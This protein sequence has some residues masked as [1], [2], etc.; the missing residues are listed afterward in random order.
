MGTE[1]IDL[2]WVSFAPHPEPTCELVAEPEDGPCTA[3]A[4]WRIIGDPCGHAKL[5][6]HPHRF[7]IE[8]FVAYAMAR[9]DEVG[10]TDGSPMFCGVCKAD[11]TSMRAEPISP[12]VTAE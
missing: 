3:V 11:V 10:F 8:A 4:A 12:E 7:E 6:C 1:P 9:A 2:S 5:S